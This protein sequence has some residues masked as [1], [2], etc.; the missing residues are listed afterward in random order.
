MTICQVEL[1]AFETI[2]SS[3]IP[4]PQYVS[5]KRAAQQLV[6]STCAERFRHQDQIE[7]FVRLPDC[8]AGANASFEA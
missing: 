5:A 8:H 3:A 4:A 6:V 7:D 1:Y 2:V